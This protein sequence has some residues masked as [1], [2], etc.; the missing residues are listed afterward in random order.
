MSLLLF[1]ANKNR[2]LKEC[3]I[4][5]QSRWRNLSHHQRWQLGDINQVGPRMA[6]DVKQNPAASHLGAKERVG[7]KLEVYAIS[8]QQAHLVII[9]GRFT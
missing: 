5:I 2:W 3:G 7:N 6:I 8:I 9:F 1:N 4:V